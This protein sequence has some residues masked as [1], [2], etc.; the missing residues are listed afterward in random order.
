MRT[1]DKKKPMIRR[2]AYKWG[3]ASG[4]IFTCNQKC[5]TC[6]LRFKCYTT[7]DWMLYLN[8]YEYNRCKL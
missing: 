4:E 5:D 8:G 7:R 6:V 2:L 1:Y 3:I